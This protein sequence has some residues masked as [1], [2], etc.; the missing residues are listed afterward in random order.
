MPHESNKSG[1]LEL[2]SKVSHLLLPIVGDAAVASGAIADGV[3]LPAILIDVSKR[4]D[5]AHLIR[6]HDE[7]PPGDVDT[8][9]AKLGGVN[10]SFA[11]I[12]EFKSPFNVTAIL[13]FD[14]ARNGILIDRI[15]QTRALYLQI[16]NAP[17]G[18]INNLGNP[19][20]IIEVHAEIEKKQWESIWEKSVRKTMRAKGVG[21]F[22]RRKAA[23]KFIET[24]RSTFE[25]VRVR[26]SSEALLEDTNL[27]YTKGDEGA[28]HPSSGPES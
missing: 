14:P 20:I 10:N 5:V 17:G 7:F 3:F 6:L 21:Y 25:N 11:L 2:Q 8:T 4:P 1:R 19:R 23:L 12:M 22:D 16:A 28:P 26:G 27:Y 15:I 13:N 9:W 24:A 18:L